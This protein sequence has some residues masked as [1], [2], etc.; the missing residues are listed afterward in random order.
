MLHCYHYSDD[1]C[2]YLDLI[3]DS[4]ISTATAFKLGN[5]RSDV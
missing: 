1:E 2:L 5:F 3:L 4:H